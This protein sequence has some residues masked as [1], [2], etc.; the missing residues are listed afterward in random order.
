MGQPA[1]IREAS[2]LKRL[3][4]CTICGAEFL[5]R[6]TCRK[7]LACSKPCLSEHLRRRKLGTTQSEETKAKRSVSLRA[8]RSDPERNA[9][10]AANAAA[11]VRKW[12]EH[13]DNAE[14]AAQEMS[15]RMRLLHQDPE[16]QARRNERSSRVMTENWKKYRDQYVSAAIKRY[17]REATDGT[18]INC[19]AKAQ[20]KVEACK[21]IMKKAKEALHNETAIDQMFTSVQARLRVEMPFRGQS[22]SED[23][24]EYLKILGKAVVEDPE[25]RALADTFMSQAIPRFAAE[26]NSL[27][28]TGGG[29]GQPT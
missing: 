7:G 14:K 5:V 12:H 17:E 2:R 19:G 24:Y 10:W 27:R 21:W 11:G 6:D 18:G 23:Y 16:F 3:R 22:E 15:S 1:H 8:V 13:P 29:D 28:A 25:Y 26:W 4:R 9:A 20:R